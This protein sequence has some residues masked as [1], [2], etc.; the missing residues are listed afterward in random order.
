[1]NENDYVKED[2]A[3]AERTIIEPKMITIAA[4]VVGS[5]GGMYYYDGPAA[6]RAS[7][8]AATALS[9]LVISSFVT[10]QDQ[11]QSHKRYLFPLE[12]HFSKDKLSPEK[13]V[14]GQTLTVENMG[15]FPRVYMQDG[16]IYDTSFEMLD[17]LQAKANVNLTKKV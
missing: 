7:I 9:V 8:G 17:E 12:P 15:D 13:V 5:V 4:A 1:M 10:I 16:S 6:V 14:S 2:V 11:R 3:E